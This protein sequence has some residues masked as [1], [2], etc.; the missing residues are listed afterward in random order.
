[1]LS[2]RSQNAICFLLAL[3][4]FPPG[5]LVSLQEI[6]IK[7][8]LPHAYLEQILPTLKKAG[9]VQSQRGAFGGYSL[10]RTASEISLWDI[11]GP[12]ER[13]KKSTTRCSSLMTKMQLSKETY[14]KSMNLLN[15][16][17]KA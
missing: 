17:T 4:E 9:L 15:I 3:S 10:A 6:T 13:N 7:E 2:T 11:V 14:L 8:G 5:R 1:M 16:P 12:L